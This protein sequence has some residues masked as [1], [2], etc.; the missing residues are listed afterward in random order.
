MVQRG[1][2]KEAEIL[3]RYVWRHCRHLMT[4][5]EIKVERAAMARGKAEGAE[6]M[7]NLGFAQHMRKE[8]GLIGDQQV[9]AALAD[10]L[11][12]F[13]GRVFLRLMT[14]PATHD[15]INRCPECRRIVATPR[16]KQCL[17]CK[18]DW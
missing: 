14:L 16:A 7:G 17:W 8:W 10:G 15:L 9:E 4:E 12:K 3:F 11:E 18:H 5:F 6:Q 1:Q 2:Y 13:R